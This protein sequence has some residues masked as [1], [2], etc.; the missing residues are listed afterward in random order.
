MVENK[1]TTAAHFTPSEAER[2]LIQ[3]HLGLDAT[4]DKG[5]KATVLLKQEQAEKRKSLVSDIEYDFQLALNKGDY[6]LGKAVINFYLVKA[7]EKD[8]LFLNF[9]AMAIANLTVNDTPVKDCFG[10]QKIRLEQPYVTVGWN[11]VQLE[12][13]NAYNKNRD[14]EYWSNSHMKT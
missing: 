11:T 14:Y 10:E 7:P 6:Y 13:F 1:D 9:Q 8:E 5:Y 2:S 3:T 4:V 12:Y